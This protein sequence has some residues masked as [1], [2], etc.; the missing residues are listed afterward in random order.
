MQN[1]VYSKLHFMEE[2]RGNKKKYI[3]IFAH[4]HICL[5]LQIETQK[6]IKVAQGG[7]WWKDTGVW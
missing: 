5:F 3:C 7:W 1:N 4:I 2:E 6:L